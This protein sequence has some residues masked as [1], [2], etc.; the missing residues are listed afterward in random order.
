MPTKTNSETITRE[1]AIPAC[2]LQ[3]QRERFPLATSDWKCIL[4]SLKLTNLGGIVPQG[5][6]LAMISVK[7]DDYA[8]GEYVTRHMGRLRSLGNWFFLFRPTDGLGPRDWFSSAS[9]GV[10]LA[11]RHDCVAKNSAFQRCPVKVGSE[12][13]R[14]G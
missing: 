12:K 2:P 8:M 14:P 11:I 10:I 7:L 3:N 5:K 6:T 4:V 9:T 1:P 13:N